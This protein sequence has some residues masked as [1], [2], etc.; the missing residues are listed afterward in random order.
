MGPASN[1]RYYYLQFDPATYRFVEFD[2]DSDFSSPSFWALA[3]D[4]GKRVAVIDMVRGPLTSGINGVQ[5]VDWLGHDRMR[6][7]RSV[8]PDL[9]GV[10]EKEFGTDPWNGHAD[11]AYRA[12]TNKDPAAWLDETIRRIDRKGA[13]SE[14]LLEAEDWDLFATV[15]SDP[16][17]FGHLFWHL[18]DPG[19][20]NFDAQWFARNGDPLETILG[21][22]DRN[23]ARLIERVG[24]D[25]HVILFTGPGMGPNY[26]ANLALDELLRRLESSYVRTPLRGRVSSLLRTTYRRALPETTRARLNLTS[27]LRSIASTDT[28]RFDPFS[29]S[30][31]RFFAV[32]NN[33]NAGAVRL[34]IAG[35]EARGLLSLA[36][37]DALLRRLSSDLR[38]IRNAE[39]GLPLIA[40]VVITKDR[41]SGPVADNLPDLLLVWNRPGPIRRIA[42]KGI[43]SMAVPQNSRRTGDHND[44]VFFAFRS[45]PSVHAEIDCARICAEDMAPTILRLMGVDVS[46]TFD[47]TARV[48]PAGGR[49]GP[50]VAGDPAVPV[51]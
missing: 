11:D 7:S 4:A 43:G 39:S 24:P 44:R 41:Y 33:H 19:H 28:D 16:H 21:A 51:S 38:E 37:A 2:E 9:M 3:S 22:I 18:H 45:A 10:V 30:G 1:G 34:N 27:R 35:R 26:S 47:G 17:D 49:D 5:I 32:P 29:L 13:Y 40:E 12:A 48:L 23:V 42:S 6:G 46:C 20:P 15:F 14:R 25:T 8:P 36:T 50:L 31:R